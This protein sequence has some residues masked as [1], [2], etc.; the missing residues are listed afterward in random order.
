MNIPSPMDPIIQSFARPSFAQPRF[1]APAG[2]AAPRP[3]MG[4]TFD[5]MMELPV[6]FGDALRLLGH[7]GMATVGLFV[8]ISQSG[9]WST[10]GWIVGLMS[11]FAALLDICSLI[12]RIFGKE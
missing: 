5:Q 11:G 2:A 9:A 7:G 10:I 1:A 6:W 4:A 3:R 12:G 8:G